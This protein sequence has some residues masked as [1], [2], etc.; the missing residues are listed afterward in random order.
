MN[1]IT[2]P[3]LTSAAVGLLLVTSVGCSK[4]PAKPT[5]PLAI[6]TERMLRS[7]AQ[8]LSWNKTGFLGK[9]GKAVESK[10]FPGPLC[11]HYFADEFTF[12]GVVEDFPEIGEV[13][14]EGTAG[15]RHWELAPDAIQVS[16][17]GAEGKSDYADLTSFQSLLDEVD[18]FKY[19][20]FK[21]NLPVP[22]W[23]DPE[24]MH[25]WKISLKF[26][27][28]ARMKNGRLASIKGFN[29]TIWDL[30]PG[31]YDSNNA[32]ERTWRCSSWKVTSLS[33]T[34]TDSWLFDEV[35]DEL[36]PD[37]QSLEL[38]RQS[39]HEGMVAEFIQAQRDGKAFKKPHPSWQVGAGERHPTV[40]VVD[41]DRDGWDDF[42]VQ[43][44]QGRNLFFRNN[45][46]GTF[47]EI[48]EE[49]GLDFVGA[50]SSTSFADFDNDGDLDAFVGGTLDRSR[51]LENV[52]GKYINRSGDWIADVNL[53]YH[54]SSVSVVDYDGDGLSDIYC[55]TYAAFYV[56][57]ALVA[58]KGKSKNP[59]K[60][61]KALTGMR[62]FLEQPDWEELE[63]LT[64]AQSKGH[65][66]HT[67]RPG[68]PNII[69]K[70]MGNGRFEPSEAADGLRI[71]YN[72]F[73]TTWSDFDNDGDP[74]MYCANDF[75]PNFMFRNEGDGTFTDVTDIMQVEDIG[76]GMAVTIGDY[77]ND[78]RQDLYVAN[79]FSKAARRITSFFTVGR[80]N[81]DEALLAGEGIDPVLEQLGRGNS[82]FHN[83]GTDTPWEKVS[84]IG[85]PLHNV[86]SAGWCW[87]TQFADFN[88]DGW[89]DIYAP[90][91]Y[92]TAPEEKKRDV[93]L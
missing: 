27:G 1:R 86:E 65:G 4:G 52:D 51:I 50:T 54:V 46:D 61:K 57:R 41:Y 24:T 68:P 31:D 40:S 60:G 92:Y 35:L 56:Q 15:T 67:N 42:Y 18:Y 39:I 49:I 74:D 13:L 91:G 71:F 78:G 43:E 77:D 6:Q 72:S 47:K 37:G 79:M 12:K 64:L 63:E 23:V 87:G 9:L 66:V 2:F 30:D 84:D 55:S 83:D 32:D 14:N 29:E 73:Q 81:Y 7:E 89:L 19:A 11:L 8:L 16:L 76:F 5:T 38:A 34:E 17:N 82:L 45:G 69:L 20:K 33:I 93:D 22:Q 28:K 80:V 21:I 48:A 70:N 58:L 59:R 36:V 3:L 62:E 44:R 88:N 25:Q 53:P 85:K 10:S 90:A 26:V 75:A